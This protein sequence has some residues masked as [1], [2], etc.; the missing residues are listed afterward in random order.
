MLVSLCSTDSG[1]SH[2]TLITRRALYTP[3]SAGLLLGIR[4]LCCWLG[5]WNEKRE[6]EEEK[7]MSTWSPLSRRVGVAMGGNW[8]SSS[9]LIFPPGQQVISERWTTARH[10]SNKPTMSTFIDR[11]DGNKTDVCLPGKNRWWIQ[12]RP[13]VYLFI[14]T[15][16]GPFR[17]LF[18]IMYRF[19]LCTARLSK[20]LT[21]DRLY[22]VTR[23]HIIRWRRLVAHTE[24]VGRCRKMTGF[25]KLKAHIPF[26]GRVHLGR[27]SYEVPI[28]WLRRIGLVDA[29]GAC[30]THRH[31]FPG[32]TGR[33]S[34][35]HNRQL[36]FH[37]KRATIHF[38]MNPSTRTPVMNG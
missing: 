20:I 26:L 37:I 1:M 17:C 31:C 9:R 11:M 25:I 16:T 23:P 35:A 21:L 15:I 13:D 32:P 34:S 12:Q 18:F 24:R 8:S 3:T 27:Y 30:Y 7:E 2:T 33:S 6:E 4:P 22:L 38:V 28:T 36:L 14:S 5:K 10:Q 19:P 29:C